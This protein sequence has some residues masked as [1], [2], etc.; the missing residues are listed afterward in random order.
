[1]KVQN[2]AKVQVNQMKLNALKKRSNIQGGG[3]D[4]GLLKE[5]VEEYETKIKNL[6]KLLYDN[7]QV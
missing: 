3:I 4:E 5:I 7:Q 2:S 6:E 1:M